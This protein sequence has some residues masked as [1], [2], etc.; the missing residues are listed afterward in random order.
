MIQR[1]AEEPGHDQQDA[2][3]RDLGADQELSRDGR[4][5]TLPGG[6]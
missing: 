2:T 4:A 3:G 6:L 1:A 5:M